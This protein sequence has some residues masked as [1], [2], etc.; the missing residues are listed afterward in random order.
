MRE[1]IRVLVRID[2]AGHHNEASNVNYS[3]LLFTSP[4][5]GRGGRSEQQQWRW[6][7]LDTL[8]SGQLSASVLAQ[9]TCAA[10][11]ISA[12]SDVMSY[13]VIPIE[14]ERDRLSAGDTTIQN[15]ALSRAHQ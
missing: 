7:Q 10:I 15:K 1:A 14:R 9:T 11:E 3:M 5:R 12:N 2:V 4:L 6:T 13:I 8:P